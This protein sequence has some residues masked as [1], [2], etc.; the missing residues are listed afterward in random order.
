MHA[1]LSNGALRLA[2]TGRTRFGGRLEV[3]QNNDWGTVCIDLWS[4]SDATAAC[5]Q[6]GFVSVND[7]DSLPFGSGISYQ[8]IWLNTVAC[9]GSES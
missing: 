3:Y 4:P 5:K 8:H 2:S 6:I 9:S 1:A 7:S